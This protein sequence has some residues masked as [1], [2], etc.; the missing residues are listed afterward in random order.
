MPAQTDRQRSKQHG[1]TLLEILVALAIVAV[2]LGA[3]IS[4]VSR[5][6]INTA[7]LRDRT[8]AHWVA[9]NLIAEQQINNKWPSVSNVKGSTTMA[10]QEWFWTLV[11]TDTADNSIR[12]LDITV[13]S[14]KDSKT[15]QSSMIAY[16]GKPTP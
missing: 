7:Q 5:H 3:V 6:L 9:M 2:A 13:D 14:S 10:K 8:I 16:L 12:R 4:E 15:P 11:I 1:F